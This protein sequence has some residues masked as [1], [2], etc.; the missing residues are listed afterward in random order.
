MVESVK[1]AFCI[2]LLTYGGLT[3]SLS[4]SMLINLYV[5]KFLEKY[6]KNFYFYFCNIICFII[7]GILIFLIW[8]FDSALILVL[9][10]MLLFGVTIG[11]NEK[12]LNKFCLEN[13]KYDK[14]GEISKLIKNN[15]DSCYLRKVIVWTFYVIAVIVN[16]LLKLNII[17]IDDKGLIFMFES[18]ECSAIILLAITTLLDNIK[19]RKEKKESENTDKNKFREKE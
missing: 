18:A 17:T 2:F 16:S 1:F 14:D 7:T 4:L 9:E 12:L 8:K 11:T 19:K 6:L 15:A 10:I 3:F 5:F 13:K